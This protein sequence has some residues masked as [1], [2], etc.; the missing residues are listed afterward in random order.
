[1]SNNRRITYLV[2]NPIVFR[3]GE[4]ST[5]RHPS[6]RGDVAMANVNDHVAE[7]MPP[8]LTA[9]Q[10][11]W[12][13]QVKSEA[14]L[15][16]LDLGIDL[17]FLRWREGSKYIHSERAAALGNLRRDL[18]EVILYGTAKGLAGK[19]NRAQVNSA[20]IEPPFDSLPTKAEL[21]EAKLRVAQLAERRRAR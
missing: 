9:E 5:R 13:D 8:A 12:S 11:A 16:L 21:I 14:Q 18:F 6:R 2:R 10:L 7:L 15:A 1:M 17:P 20:S 4:A 19:R 3:S